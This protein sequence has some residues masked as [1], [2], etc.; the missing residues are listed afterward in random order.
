MS[1]F[2]SLSLVTESLVGSAPSRF[3]GSTADALA[4]MLAPGYLNDIQKKIKANDVFDIN[5]L[6]TSAFPLDTGEAAIFG[7]FKVQYDPTL[8]NWNLI[9]SSAPSSI[10]VAYGFHSDIYTNAGGSAT[11]VVTDALVN[12]NSIVIARWQSSANAVV[13]ETVAPANG[14]FTVVSSGNPGASVLEYFSFLPSV[15]LQNIGVYGAQ[16]TTANA[17]A[18][19]TFTISNPNITAAMVANANFVSQTNASKIDTVIAGAGTITVVCSANPGA[20]VIVY[21]AILPSSALTA[22]GLYANTYSNAG[23]SATTTIT[24][25]NITA[26]SVVVADWASQANAVQIEKV[27]PSASTLTILSSADPGA[28]VL[29]YAAT[30]ADEGALAGIYLLAANNLSDVASASTALANLGGVPLAG[31]QLTG[32]V[33]TQKG[34]G[35]VSTGAVTINDQSGVITT[36]SLTTAAAATTAVTFNNSKIVST[37]VILVSLMGGTNT[38]PGVQLSCVYSSAG[39]ATLNITNNNVAGSALNG[40]L[41]IGFVVL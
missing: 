24:D 33:L 15:A 40:T 13:V 12:Q 34:T 6:D 4:T 37:S 1:N 16:Y 31:G 38:I 17:G 32:S 19:T 30:P 27:T 39:V 14:S 25:S 8:N 10:I 7:S 29:N 41:L 5:Y 36:G 11:V 2:E 20:C 21:S 3:V 35:T 18:A 26:A 9:P 23:G 28:S 22:D